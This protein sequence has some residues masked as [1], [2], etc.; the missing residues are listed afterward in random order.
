MQAGSKN[1]THCSDSIAIPM[2]DDFPKPALSIVLFMK[3]E[4]M[5]YVVLMLIAI[6]GM[7]PLLSTVHATDNN[8]IQVPFSEI[9]P[10]IDGKFTSETEWSD[11]NVTGFNS[12]GYDFYLLTQ[13]NGDFVYMMFDGVDFQTDPK[14]G[15]L[16][17][18][19]Q[20]TLCIDGNNDKGTER[21]SGDFCNT[22]TV[23]NEFGRQIRGENAPIKF[24]SE[25]KSSHLDLPNEFKT[26]WGYGSQ[27]NPFEESDHLTFEV[28]MPRILFESV[29]DVG[30]VFEMYAGSSS[31]DVVQLIDGIKWPTESDKKEPSTWGDLVLPALRCAKDLESV[32]K[33]SDSSSACVKPETKIT[34]IERGWGK[35]KISKVT[36]IES[37]NT[38]KLIELLESGQVSEFNNLKETMDLSRTQVSL[39][40]ADLHGVDLRKINLE[41]VHIEHAN[42]K[43]ANLQGIV[44][45]YRNVQY[46]DLRGAN[47]SDADISDAYLY[48]VNLQG[49]D[50][51]GASMKNTHINDSDMSH[52]NLQDADLRGVNLQHASL[53]G[54]NFQGAVL[55][56]AVMAETDLRKMN[57]DGANMEFANLEYA[58]LRDARLQNTN[59]QNANLENADLRGA[60]LSGA[61][62]QGANLNNADLLGTN[63]S[64]VQ[65]IP[66][67]KEE[68]RQRGAIT[69]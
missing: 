42:M 28:Q 14:R 8:S 61:D 27:D 55:Q 62:L 12:N 57:F 25:G 22:S 30:F 64:N 32:F 21:E 50:L 34:L 41:S 16:S 33:I 69:G 45:D 67:S 17:V 7:M 5:R 58:D 6:I 15:D 19:Y 10:E 20:T 60:N 47:L 2:N 52:A 31:T 66:I 13:Q 23:F 1:M 51:T 38:Q 53:V 35:D 56:G 18:R 4:K 59:M 36:Q 39:E 3:M 37:N 54:T 26:E 63:L 65:N 9:M 48:G 11:A 24:D 44:L 46:A 68:A 29:D 49:A 40:G 43:D